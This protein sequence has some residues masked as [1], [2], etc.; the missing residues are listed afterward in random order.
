MKALHKENIFFHEYS[1]IIT[2]FFEN[3]DNYRYDANGE[4]IIN[5]SE[6]GET[7][8][9]SA[10]Y[11]VRNKTVISKH[12]FAGNQRIASTVSMKNNCGTMTEQN[13][14]YFHPDHLGSSSYVTDKK[15]NFFEMIEYLPYGETLYDEAATVDKTEFRFTSK[16]Q[17]AETGLYYYGA[18]YYDAKLCKWISTDPI[19][20]KYLNNIQKKKIITK[21]FDLYQYGHNNQ[22]NMIDPDGR[23]VKSTDVT[24]NEKILTDINRAAGGGFY[25]DKNN[26]LQLKEGSE[27][28][29]KY[30]KSFRKILM[31]E[32]KNENKDIYIH[33]GKSYKEKT[34]QGEDRYSP[35]YLK[36]DNLPVGRCGYADKEG[37]DIFVAVSDFSEM[38][39]GGVD[40]KIIID[41]RT[42]ILMHELGGHGIPTIRG[43]KGKNAAYIGIEM[44]KEAGINNYFWTNKGAND[45]H[46]GELPQQGKYEDSGTKW[47]TP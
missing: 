42:S 40:K 1:H 47:L 34:I 45:S 44:I 15:G 16:E 29:G 9:V 38:E 24:Q 37:K 39:K 27:P 26:E 20:E 4:R 5:K 21:D 14:M 10:N 28:T 25:F 43:L 35:L 11:I 23:K 33:Y 8:Y 13:T 18:R 30:S 22:I 36:H 41:A 17:D 6:L 46:D 3:R 31:E 7:Q 32:I 19:L 12:V 2:F